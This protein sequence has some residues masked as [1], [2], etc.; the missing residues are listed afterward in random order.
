MRRNFLQIEYYGILRTESSDFLL[1]SS[2]ENNQHHAGMW[3]SPFHSF[4]LRQNGATQI[5][6]TASIRTS[7]QPVC[8]SIGD[9]GM[10]RWP[11]RR[12]E[13]MPRLEGQKAGANLGKPWWWLYGCG[14]KPM[15]SHFGVGAPPI[16]IG[17]FTGGMRF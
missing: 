6:E 3:L 8:S 14:S 1:P 11:G 15:A 17:M 2:M 5:T 9:F 12:S 16:G 10:A 13:S 4:E 7:P